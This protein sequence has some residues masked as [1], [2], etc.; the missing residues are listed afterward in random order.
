LFFYASQRGTK[1][2]QTA[3]QVVD[4]LII[5]FSNCR[6][7][8]ADRLSEHIQYALKYSATW[9]IF[10]VSKSCARIPRKKEQVIRDVSDINTEPSP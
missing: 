2:V 8:Y 10:C 6:N 4:L 5:I 9:K 7:E 1:R 3:E